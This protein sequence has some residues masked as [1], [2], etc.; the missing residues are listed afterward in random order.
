MPA[1]QVPSTVMQFTAF[2]I[3]LKNKAQLNITTLVLL[4]LCCSCVNQSNQQASIPTC[5]EAEVA[6]QTAQTQYNDFLEAFAEKPTDKGT[7]SRAD[8]IQTL[9]DA[10]ER[11]FDSC[12]NFN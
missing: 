4:S 5:R 8:V 9:Q 1:S 12:Q 11:A 7:I 10:E 3:Q 2:Y 6:V